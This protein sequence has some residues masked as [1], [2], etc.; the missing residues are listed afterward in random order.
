M[1]ETSEQPQLYLITPPE[2]ELMRFPGQLAACLDAVPVACVR[3]ALATRD[4]DRIARAA[5]ALR[6]LTHERDI[7]LVID[8]HLIMVERLG[9]DGVHLTDSARSVRS[10]RKALGDEAIVGTFCGTSRHD[11]MTAGELS[12]DYIS[13]G[14]VG[15]T[16]LG[17]GR[18]AE[19]ELFQWWSEM[20]E[21]PCVAEGALDDSLVRTLAPYTDFFGIGDEIWNTDDPVVALRALRNAMI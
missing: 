3:L 14:P 4:E 1:S 16:A 8:T 13:F 7:A 2:I 19:T 12:A 18:R 17:D 15:D 9:L 10:A 11:G 21:V 6:E 20:I 5:D